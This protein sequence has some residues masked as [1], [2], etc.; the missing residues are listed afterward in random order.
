M[1][2]TAKLANPCRSASVAQFFFS[3]ATLAFHRQDLGLLG[4]ATISST[5]DSVT[6]KI[7]QSVNSRFAVPSEPRRKGASLFSNLRTQVFSPKKPVINQSHAHSRAWWELCIHKQNQGEWVR[8]VCVRWFSW[9]LEGGGGRKSWKYS[10]IE[11]VRLR[12]IVWRARWNVLV[13]VESDMC[14]WLESSL[15]GGTNAMQRWQQKRTFLLLSAETEKLWRMQKKN[16]FPIAA[17]SN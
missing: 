13:H 7:L 16:E 17:V 10:T 9:G 3:I 5:W 4:W 8:V 12:F 15:R 6:A 14:S 11:P 2:R 1:E